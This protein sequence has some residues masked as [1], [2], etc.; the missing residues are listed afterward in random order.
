MISNN[1]GDTRVSGSGDLSFSFPFPLWV[2]ALLRVSSI[3]SV[4][5][6]WV[7]AFRFLG[8]V[9]CGAEIAA[10]E[11][12]CLCSLRRPRVCREG[13]ATGAVLS[14]RSWCDLY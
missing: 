10:E 12:I 7:L 6:G 3:S 1:G 11:T 4:L 8:V 5:E 9:G 2:D 13:P 14:M